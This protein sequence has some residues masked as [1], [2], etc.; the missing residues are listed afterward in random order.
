[1][2]RPHV[3]GIHKGYPFYTIGQRKGLGL[4]TGYPIYV[5]E[6]NKDK[7]EIMV[8]TFDE[9][10]R[11]GMYVDKLNFMK[12]DNIKGKI[13]ANV[14]IRYNDNGSPAIIE[15]IEDSI[16]VFFGNGVN[17]ITPGQAAVFYEKDDVIGG[18]WIKSSF[19]QNKIKHL[20]KIINE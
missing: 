6:I 3:L 17:A 7:N 4:A 19:K 12:Y 14:K 20:K 15:K 18:G 13:D 9:L 2:E 11:D 1:M 8:G 16:K 5:T 10:K